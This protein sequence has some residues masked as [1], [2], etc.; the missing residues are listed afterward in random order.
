MPPN[1][2][3]PGDTPAREPRPVR[4]ERGMTLEHDRFHS[5]ILRERGLFVVGEG[6]S[7]HIGRGDSSMPMR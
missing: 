7:E 6:A 3:M 1:T 2:F 5:A 4:G